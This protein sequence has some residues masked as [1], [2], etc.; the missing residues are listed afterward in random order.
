[1]TDVNAKVYEHVEYFAF[2]E[3]WV[4]ENSNQQNTPYLFTGKEFD[5]ETGRRRLNRKEGGESF[6]WEPKIRERLEA[7]AGR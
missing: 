3:T 1:V 7:R 4:L 5:E 2:G 6:A